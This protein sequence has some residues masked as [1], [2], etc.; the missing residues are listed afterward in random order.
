MVV[1]GAGTAGANVAAQMAR[2]GRSVVVLERRPAGEGGANWHNGVLAWQFEAAG[3]DPP[4][5]P[6]RATGISGV[7]HIFGPD[8]SPGVTVRDN[9]VMRADMG[10]LG[11]RLRLAATEAGAEI[12]DRARPAEVSVDRDGRLRSLVVDRTGAS[13]GRTGGSQRLEADLFVDTSGHRGVLR[14]HVPALA[15]WCP[16]VPGGDLC[17]ASDHDIEVADPAGAERFLE[18]HGAQPGDAVTV[19]GIDGGWS[20]RSVTVTRDL[21]HAAVLVGCVADGAHGP[22]PRLLAQTLTEL[23]WLGRSRS[24][25]TGIIP[26]R[27]PYSRITAPGV[28]LVGDSAG[29]VFPAHGSGIGLGLMAGRMLAD[30]VKG[31]G[32]CG[33]EGVLWRYQFRFQAEHGG[34]L[35]ASD[36]FRRMSVRLGSDGVGRMVGA[37]LLDEDMAR[38]G[39]DQRWPRL[40]L[41]QL[42][43]QAARLMSVP[44]VAA[45]MVPMLIRARLLVEMGARHPTAPDEEALSRWDGT[46]SRLIVEPPLVPSTGCHPG[47]GFGQWGVNLRERLVRAAGGRRSPR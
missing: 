13:G 24:G 34:L 43:A 37:G 10:A 8:G 26:L 41:S 42:P 28:A 6:E 47:A 46:V 22:G 27:R 14:H 36:A 18:L 30:A 32:D 31:V 5:P 11:A 4:Q 12:V 17:T 29:Q 35:A 40:D 38:A 15:R 7:T 25:G 1:L 19:V 33:A 16:R 44:G 20:T 45:K 23:R 3:V 39:L 9:P 21:D 2:Q